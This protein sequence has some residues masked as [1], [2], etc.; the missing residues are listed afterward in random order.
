MLDK[1]TLNYI[2]QEL[3]NVCPFPVQNREFFKIQIKSDDGR[4]TKWLNIKPAQ[5]KQI[6]NVLLGLSPK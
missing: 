4:S 1:T 3:I 6:E 5:F 2:N